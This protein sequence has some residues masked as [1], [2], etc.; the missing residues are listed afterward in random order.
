MA[1]FNVAYE[2]ADGKTRHYNTF[3]TSKDRAELSL[4]QFKARYLNE[5]GTGKPYP[6]G[7]GFYPFTNPRVVERK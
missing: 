2:G 1:R 3:D 6:N 5:D 7:L 4:L